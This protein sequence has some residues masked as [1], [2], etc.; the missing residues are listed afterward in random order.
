MSAM[1]M[2][3]VFSGLAVGTIYALVALGFTIIYNSSNVINFAQGEFVMLGGMLSVL[4]FKA[5]V[6][7]CILRFQQ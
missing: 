6:F 5:L 7:L 3:F 1:F 4:F 2:Q